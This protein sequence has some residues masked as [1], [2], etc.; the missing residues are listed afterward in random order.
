MPE[1]IQL[2]ETHMDE[3]S[4]YPYCIELWNK[5]TGQR[6]EV[7]KANKDGSGWLFYARFSKEAFIPFLLQE[8]FLDGDFDEEDLISQY[9][10]ELNNQ[11][12][13]EI[14]RHFNRG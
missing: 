5:S 14:A 12:N 8:I 7:Y 9:E 10:E 13:R 11:L 6:A 4:E 1:L 3:K 2:A